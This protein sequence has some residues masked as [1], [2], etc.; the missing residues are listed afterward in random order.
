MDK[1]SS[2][3]YGFTHFRQ[4]Y[5]ELNQLKRHNNNDAKSLDAKIDKNS[6][7]L[8][9]LMISL[10]EMS[11]N[12]IR[13]RNQKYYNRATQL[14]ADLDHINSAIK[15]QRIKVEQWKSQ[16]RLVDNDFIKF[17]IVS[18]EFDTGKDIQKLENRIFKN[19]KKKNSLKFEANQLRMVIKDLLL[20]RRIFQTVRDSM[21]AQLLENKQKINQS[22]HQFTDR[23]RINS[24][25]TNK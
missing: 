24:L 23:E 9:A 18:G 1:H 10:K 14:A 16:I 5:R 3:N 25:Q 22:V 11:N 6:K 8:E 17:S 2:E 20:K 4:V 15:L 7:K 12:Q 13:A 21:I 19:N